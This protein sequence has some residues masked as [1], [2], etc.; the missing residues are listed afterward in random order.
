LLRIQLLNAWRET[1]YYSAKE[2]AALAL[3]EEM[4]L[5]S[6]NQVSDHTYQVAEQQLN[7]AEMSAIEWL[8]IVINAWNRIAIASR[9][10]VAPD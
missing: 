10:N 5:I 9:Y 8:S 1:E 2:R 6:H 4:T 7:Q 3:I